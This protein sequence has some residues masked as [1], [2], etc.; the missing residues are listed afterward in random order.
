MQNV[1]G[2]SD[3][4]EAMLDTATA[5]SMVRVANALNYHYPCKIIAVN[6]SKAA[7]SFVPGNGRWSIH[8]YCLTART[9]SSLASTCT[10]MTKRRFQ[11]LALTDGLQR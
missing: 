6:K 2:N 7:D 10:L 3:V 11:A 5:M 8:P 1:P 4:D 9:I